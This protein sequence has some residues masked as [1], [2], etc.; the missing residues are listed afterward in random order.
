MAEFEEISHQLEKAL[1]ILDRLAV[2]RILAES[3]SFDGIFEFAD[4]VIVPVLE[5]IG[6]GWEQGAVALSQYYMSSR[7]LEESLSAVLPSNTTRQRVHPRIAITTLNDYHALGRRIVCSALQAN[8]F[9]LINYGRQEVDELVK[10]VAEDGIRVLLVS[11]LL[12]PSAL[13]VK[14]LIPELNKARCDTKVVVGGA[15]FRFDGQLWQEVGADAMGRTA[16]EAIA[17]VSAMTGES[18]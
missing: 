14:D 11:V 18:E 7:I 16:S 10:S 12:L 17:I 4:R 5:K 3:H 8:G 15:P 2:K 13:M 9:K 1:L 6:E